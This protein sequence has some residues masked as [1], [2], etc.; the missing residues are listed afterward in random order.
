LPEFL[1]TKPV[2]MLIRKLIR[3]NL[4]AGDFNDDVLGG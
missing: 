3:K 1:N 4:C 2:E